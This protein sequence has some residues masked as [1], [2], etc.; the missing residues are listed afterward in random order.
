[1]N[2]NL[3]LVQANIEHLDDLSSMFNEYR[4][5]YKQADDINACREFLQQ[6]LVQQQSEAFIA[7][8]DDKAAG[9]IHLYPSFSSVYLKPIW[10]MNDLYVRSFARRQGVGFA[11][12]DKAKEMAE[13][14]GAHFIKL[15]TEQRNVAAQQVYQSK[16]YRRDQSFYHFVLPLKQ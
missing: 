9:F 2:Q 11:L 15:S 12:L 1:M 3:H 4:Q 14:S 6:R 7:Y 8:I 13:T 16:G 10:T 5:F